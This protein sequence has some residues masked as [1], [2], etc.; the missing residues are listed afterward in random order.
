MDHSPGDPEKGSIVEKATPGPSSASKKVPIPWWCSGK[1]IGLCL[2][3]SVKVCACHPLL[4][5]QVHTQVCTSAQAAI[6]KI[7]KTGWLEQQ[8]LIYQSSRGWKSKIKIW[9]G[10]VSGENPIS[11][12]Q[13][14]PPL[15]GVLTWQRKPLLIMLE[16]CQ[17]RV[18]LLWPHLT[19]LP[20][21]TS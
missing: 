21:L 1:S 18:P 4:C 17:I 5:T 2:P 13:V 12:L 6:N 15:P 3:L 8:K 10:L 9:Q 16:S 14:S 11:G 7:P 19:S 20:N